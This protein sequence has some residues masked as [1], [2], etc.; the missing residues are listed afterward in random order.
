MNFK[1]LIMPNQNSLNQL[2]YGI[3]MCGRVLYPPCKKKIKSVPAQKMKEEE[4]IKYNNI[5]NEL[6]NELPK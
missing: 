1:L 6:K 5:I 4:W 3:V 2:A